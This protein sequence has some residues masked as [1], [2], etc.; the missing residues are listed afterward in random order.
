VALQTR[1]TFPVHRRLSRKGLGKM[2]ELVQRQ[3]SR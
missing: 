1:W 3:K 2:T